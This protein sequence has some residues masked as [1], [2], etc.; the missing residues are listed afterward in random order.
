MTVTDKLYN[1]GGCIAALGTFDGVHIGHRAVIKKA[2][3][4]G[5]PVVVVTSKQNPRQLISG[6]SG[7]ILSESLCDKAFEALG[8]SG[9]VRLDFEDIRGLSPESYL[10][11]L[12]ENLGAKG[13]A[14]GYNF[15]FGK[16]ASGNVDTL[17]SYTN[18]R[19]LLCSVCE[20]VELDGKAVSSTRIR[21]ALQEGN[22]I[23]AQ[24]LLGRPYSIDFEVVHGEKRG[25][26]MGF[27]TINQP[28]PESF[29][30]PRFGV[31]AA[32]AEI[33]GVRYPAVTNIGVKPT[34]GCDKV[35]AETNICGFEKE[36][37]G[38]TPI[39]TLVDF[40]RCETKFESV[41]ELMMQ[42]AK[43]KEIAIGIIEKTDV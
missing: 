26:Q 9:V 5:L 1:T 22:I 14:S 42:I 31:Y 30:L 38:K 10:D 37:Y 17:R 29:T 43:D 18:E 2:L 7:R 25:R 21:Q 27:P 4:L 35:I 23:A 33:D 13:F 11:M 8:V 3:G 16:G 36:I 20:S 39:I 32:V 41:D 28:Y 15:R 34:F 24:K 6:D 40:I 19:S 12:C